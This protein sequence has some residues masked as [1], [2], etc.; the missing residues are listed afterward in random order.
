MVEF[1]TLVSYIEYFPS[2][3]KTPC[4]FY[5]TPFRTFSLTYEE[6][7]QRARRTACYLERR[8]FKKGDRILF[9]GANSPRWAAAFFGCLLKGII[10]V[11]MDIRTGAAF[12]RSIF[13]FTKA[14]L[15]LCDETRKQDLGPLRVMSFEELEKESTGLNPQG[16]NQVFIAPDDIAEIIFT[17]GTTAEPKGVVLTHRNIVSNVEALHRSLAGLGGAEKWLSLLPLSHIFEQTIGL[18]LPMRRGYSVTYLKVLKVSSIFQAL[19]EDG[20]TLVPIVPRLLKLFQD[21]ILRE[22]KRMG[23]ER[24][25]NFLLRFSDVLPQ[26]FRRFLFPAL[27]RKFGRLKYFVAGGAT[28]ELEL[29]RFWARLGIG[30]LQGYGLTETSP[31]ISCNF[32][33]QYRFGSIG[34]I[35]SG[36]EMKISPDGEIGAR[37]PGVFSGY[38]ESP[39]KTCEAFERGWFLTGDLGRLDGDGFLYYLGRK[40]ELIVTEEGL[41]VYPADLEAVLHQVSGVKESCVIS[42]KRDGRETIHAVLLL[43]DRLLE[44]KALIDQANAHLQDFQKIQSFSVWPDEDF[45]RT[46]TMKVQKNKVREILEREAA[47]ARLEMPAEKAVPRLYVM[48]AQLA[49]LRPETLTP[50]M[51]LGDDLGLSSLDRVELA[52]M[53]EEEF[54]LD[55]DDAFLESGTSLEQVGQMVREK[56]GGLKGR[57]IP[58]W[59]V[60]P[61]ACAF[62]EMFQN[63]LIFPAVRFFCRIQ[64][65]DAQKLE[66]IQGPVI[67][68]ANHTSYFD[69][70]VIFA[71]LPQRIRRRVAV[72]TWKEFFET[73]SRKRPF[74]WACRRFEYYFASLGFNIY[75]FSREKGFKRNFEHTGWLIDRGF[76]VLLFPEGARTKTGETAAFEAGIGMLINAV[77]VPVV[78][79]GLKGLFEIFPVQRNFP[80]RG[81]VICRFGSPLVLSGMTQQDIVKKL[82]EEVEG[83]LK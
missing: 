28:L 35:L 37:G 10:V 16:E 50:G 52:A 36:V 80:R 17:S 26:R 63:M 19:E 23:K 9:W 29:E 3:G 55:V 39:E 32:P 41:N 56:E 20:I 18:W 1:T 38:Y 42:F 76:H 15:V 21:G 79:V 69:A 24:I 83:L 75:L 27:K 4:L 8:G 60:R 25:F 54:H 7:Y 53:L 68:V 47:G 44:P 43:E 31:V 45:P 59:P 62:R 82:Q 11:P 13:D 73:D 67:F 71:S 34:K 5:K 22:V 77:D 57:V 14:A 58:R 46:S 70:P 65:E 78:P 74:F 64:V 72:A 6:L 2:R 49:R 66:A 33:L 61:W 40:K 81:S 48:A 30:L 51:R 12:V